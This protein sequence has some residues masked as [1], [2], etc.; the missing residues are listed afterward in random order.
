MV[1][2]ETDK[3]E[4]KETI[5]DKLPKEIEAF[6]NS[7]G[8]SIYIGIKDNGEIIGIP[9]KQIDKI[10]KS[11]SDIITDQILPRCLNY[12]SIQLKSL[13]SKDIIKIHIEKEMVYFI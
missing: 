4:Y 3:V 11:I 8:G 10:M 5:N 12:V 7:D 13:E 9:K 6:L 2:F 1:F